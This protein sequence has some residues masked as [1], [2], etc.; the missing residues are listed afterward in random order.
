MVHNGIE[1]GMMQAFAE[2]FALMQAKPDFDLDLAAIA[3]MW[4]HGS[5]VR[6]W[7]LDLT[8]DFLASDQTLDSDRALRGG[9][10]RG[11]LDRARIGR[12]G[13]ADTGDDARADDA[14][15]HPGQERLLGENAG[16]DAPGLWWPRREGGLR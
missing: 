8:T 3:E 7:L 11:P 10:G 1:Y 15:R 13:R 12:A 14:L 6:S 2:G 4:R 9:F 16:Q 5:V